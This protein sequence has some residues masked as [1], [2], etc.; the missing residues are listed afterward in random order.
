MGS[1]W[2]GRMPRRDR[3]RWRRSCL[4]RRERMVAIKVGLRRC[5]SD[6]VRV[7]MKRLLRFW[8]VHMLPEFG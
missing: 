7:R 6:P 5:W 4:L 1:R 8:R 2:I 3:S